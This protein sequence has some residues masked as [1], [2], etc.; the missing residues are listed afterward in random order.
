MAA[1]LAVGERARVGREGEGERNSESIPSLSNHDGSI[2][3]TQAVTRTRDVL[4]TRLT[5]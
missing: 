5:G 2:I 3:K 4:I 1:R